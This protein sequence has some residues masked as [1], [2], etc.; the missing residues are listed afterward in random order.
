MIQISERNTPQMSLFVA[1]FLHCVCLDFN[2]Q[3]RTT[4][5]FVLL[6]ILS[7]SVG[8]TDADDKPTG[9]VGHRFP[10]EMKTYKD[11]RTG[12]LVTA[13]TTNPANDDKIYQTHPSWTAD[14]RWVVFQS[15]RT[16]IPQLFAVHEATGDIVQLTDAPS[17]H[18]SACISRRR[19][20]LL[21][22][23]GRQIVQLDFEGLLA[24]TTSQSARPLSTI[25][26]Q[27]PDGA[28]CTGLPSW[29]SKEDVLYLGLEWPDEPVNRRWSVHAL[30]LVNGKLTE[31]LRQDFRITHVQANPFVVGL[32]MYAQETG[33][34]AAQRMWIANADRSLNQPFYRETYD[35]WVT[36]EV[37]WDEE[38]ALFTIWPRNEEMRKKPHGI[39]SV[40][41]QGNL[42]VNSVFPYWHVTGAR[43]SNWAVGD[44]FEG[45]IFRVDLTTG[46]RLPLTQG[47]RVARSGLHPHPTMSPDGK[48][49]LF[50]SHHF[51]NPDLFLVDL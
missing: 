32:F 9:G 44:T 27:L 34:D 51:G 17:A 4:Y 3:Y 21:M 16:A 31:L 33:G 6:M 30:E 13:L 24:E 48:R 25:V 29:D 10:S 5:R 46:E 22:I 19:N 26:G 8:L 50:V 41:L 49:V 20:V 7:S 12:R 11:E 39:A 37:W 43:G 47:H 2:I 18:S 1:G 45:D 38:H 35:E 42:K 15:D 36:H 14:G 28:Q 23:E 40:D